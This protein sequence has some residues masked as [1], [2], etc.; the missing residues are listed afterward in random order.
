MSN[1]LL[2]D[3]VSK[4]NVASRARVKS[5]C[6]KNTSICF[7]VLSILEKQGLVLSFRV[8]DF[9]K[10]IVFLKYY[11]N[12]SVFY[13]IKVISKPGNRVFYTLSLMSNFFSKDC[14]SGF[15]IISTNFGLVTSN[16]CI[17]GSCIGGEVL[18]KVFV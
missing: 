14:F 16:D 15:Y 13:R 1:Y 3:L 10:I 17:L 6:V 4:I 2:S 7:S 8:D 11:E 9:D 12:R 5:I 18:L